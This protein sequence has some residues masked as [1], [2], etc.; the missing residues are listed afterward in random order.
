M[1]LNIWTTR[2]SV[3]GHPPHILKSFW[4]WEPITFTPTVVDSG[5]CFTFVMLVVSRFI[6]M[7]RAGRLATVWHYAEIP[8]LVLPLIPALFTC[9]KNASSG[10][11]ASL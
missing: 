11:P 10:T 4:E 9:S 7:F 3:I 2:G 1:H 8:V 6:P 5:Q